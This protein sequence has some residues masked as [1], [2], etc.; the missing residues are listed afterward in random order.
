MTSQPSKTKIHPGIRT[1]RILYFVYFAANGIF[2]TYINVYYQSLG[3]S[4]TQIGFVNTLSPL[5]AIL[6]MILWGVL[7]DRFAR[8][9]LLLSLS[10]AGAALSALA[11]STAQSFAVIV[12]LACTFSLLANPIIPLLDSTTLGLLG[13]QAH[14]YGRQRV[15]GSVGFIVTTA[16]VGF[17]LDLVGLHGMFLSFALVM[18]VMLLVSTRLPAQPVH[19]GSF[20]LTG[21]NKMLRHPS[22][23]IFTASVFLLGLSFTGIFNFIGVTMR[24]MGATDSL[25]GLAWTMAAVSEIPVMFFSA[26]LLRRFTA[27]R[28]V[29]VAFGMYMLR[30]ALYAIM[31]SPAWV[32]GIHLIFGAGFGLY[33]V[34]AV[35]YL[36]DIAPAGLTTTA[37]SLLTSTTGMANVL[38]ALICGWLFDRVGPSGLY[39]ILTVVSLMAFLLFAGGQVALRRQ[40]P[41]VM[42]ESS[43]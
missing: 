39:Q 18:G 32:L 12:P 30:C 36:S 37:Q 41:Q 43:S 7:N 16:S 11:L 14:T 42:T 19:L 1:M 9:R 35:A 40:Q 23:L 17:L 27:T 29:A 2:F 13:E 25:I 15:W 6:G 20:T 22:W 26:H 24:L 4:G 28:L 3:L 21:L 34:G 38:G 8:T 31:P 10:I 33:W 5:T